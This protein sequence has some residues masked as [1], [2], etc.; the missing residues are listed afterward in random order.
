MC[1]SITITNTN[2]IKANLLFEIQSYLAKIMPF[3][4]VMNSNNK[5]IQS[6][7]QH[8]FPIVEGLSIKRPAW[9]P[10]MHRGKQKL[11]ITIQETISCVQYDSDLVSD[12]HL[13]IGNLLC[14]ADLEGLPD[15]TIPLLVNMNNNSNNNKGKMNSIAYHTCVQSQDT[16]QSKNT[17][18]TTL[19]NNN[20]NNNNSSSSSSMRYLV[21]KVTFS[22][23]LDCFILCKYNIEDVT[24]VPIRG[25]YQMKEITKKEVKLLVQLKYSEKYV[26]NFQYCEMELPFGNRGSIVHIDIV[27]TAGAV[28]ISSNRKS[29][30]WNIGQKFTNKSLE[31]SLPATVYFDGN[32]NN[33]IDDPF[34]Q[35]SNSYVQ[36]RFKIIGDTLSNATIDVPNINI[37]NNSNNTKSNPQIV[38]EREIQSDEYII[39]NSL[40]ETKYSLPT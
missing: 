9:K 14:I 13:C 2:E 34:M 20:N 38:I 24:E 8:G 35:N 33:E 5:D 37:Y 1:N 32:N 27:P 11:T 29:L 18:T 12:T 3:G 22:P 7:I 16:N 15:I 31:V 39:Y 21:Q 10:Y 26:N 40:G 28:T 36:L 6:M 4:K 19:N 30:K 23:P 25:F 17:I